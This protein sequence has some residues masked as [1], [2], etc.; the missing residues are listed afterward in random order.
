M[1]RSSQPTPARY[2]QT[3]LD[4]IT[5]WLGAGSLSMLSGLVPLHT[6]LFGW[7]LP[8]WLVA[9]PLLLLLTVAPE[10]PAQWL[11]RCRSRRRSVR[12]GIWS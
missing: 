12:A 10:L 11:R 2:R 9:A 8:F 6:A 7:S 4:A 3:T 1:Y 5:L